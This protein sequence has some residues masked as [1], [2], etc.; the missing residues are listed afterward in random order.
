MTSSRTSSAPSAPQHRDARHPELDLDRVKRGGSQSNAMAKAPSQHGVRNEL[1]LI[2]DGDH[3][4][5]RSDMRL[6][7]YGR[8]EAFLAANLGQP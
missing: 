2:K 5:W 4:L 3:G 1:V 8:L 7:L 6:T